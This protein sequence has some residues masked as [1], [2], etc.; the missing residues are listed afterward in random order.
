VWI[1]LYGEDDSNVSLSQTRLG[2]CW[3]RLG[4]Y[5]KAIDFYKLA[6]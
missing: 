2:F 1:N 4:E 5:H 3:R 6:H